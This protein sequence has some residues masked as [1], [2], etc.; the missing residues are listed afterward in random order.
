MTLAMSILV[1]IPVWGYSMNVQALTAK[2]IQTATQLLQTPAMPR[3]WVSLWEKAPGLV[4]SGACICLSVMW[5]YFFI[6]FSG[7]KSLFKLSISTKY[8]WI[9]SHTSRQDL[10]T[11]CG[12]W[13]TVIAAALIVFVRSAISFLGP[14]ISP[15]SPTIREH[16]QR[17]HRLKRLVLT[18]SALILGVLIRWRYQHVTR[19]QADVFLAVLLVPIFV[20]LGLTPIGRCKCPRCGSDLKQLQAEQ[21]GRMKRDTRKPWEL[22]D[23]C[24][25]CH[26]SFDEPYSS[27]PSST[28]AMDA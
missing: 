2:R 18:I 1:G 16:F 21:V 19:L 17:T 25:N 9:Y 6:D 4:L 14:G 5:A 27:R 11:V 24:P 12:I 26:V 10:F 20:A 13:L 23:A 7:P 3:S 22:W 8:W 28:P 15:N